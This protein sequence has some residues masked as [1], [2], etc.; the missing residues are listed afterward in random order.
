MKPLYTNN[1]QKLNNLHSIKMEVLGKE[2]HEPV[3]K[4]FIS[5]GGCLKNWKNVYMR[6][7]VVGIFS[8]I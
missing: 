6:R 3:A 7:D 4:I 1:I 8:G 5:V 2:D